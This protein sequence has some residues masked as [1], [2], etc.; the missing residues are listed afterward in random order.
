MQLGITPVNAKPS[1]QNSENDDT[2]KSNIRILDFLKTKIM[3]SSETKPTK[4]IND[5]DFEK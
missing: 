2:Q 5:E 1:I 4:P 3:Q